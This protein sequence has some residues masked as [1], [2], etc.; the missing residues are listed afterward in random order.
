MAVHER[1]I[2]DNKNKDIP[3]KSFGQHVGNAFADGRQLK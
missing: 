3:M 1:T 2:I